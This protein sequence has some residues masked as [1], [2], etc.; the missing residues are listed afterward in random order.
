M[1]VLVNRPYRSFAIGMFGF[2]L[3]LAFVGPTL[4]HTFS[5]LSWD[6]IF[7]PGSPQLTN[8]EFISVRE[9][10]VREFSR[11]VT[12]LGILLALVGAFHWWRAHHSSSS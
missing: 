3:I 11:L 10:L 4:L 2:G 6:R 1:K 5:L 7:P 8:P 12:G 9:S